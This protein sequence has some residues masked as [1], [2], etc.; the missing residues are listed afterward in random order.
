VR[1]SGR[2]YEIN[3]TQAD[4]EWAATTDP[5]RG[6]KRQAGKMAALYAEA[7]RRR[8]IIESDLLALE[9]AERE[10]QLVEAV[11][12]ER[13]RRREAERV[14]NALLSLPDKLAP[15]IAAANDAFIVHQMLTAAF[16]KTLRR[17]SSE[18]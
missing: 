14:I 5:L 17:L 15:L 10:A 11:A 2:F 7:R 13:E 18:G 12:V 8:T 4:R 1:R 6:G 3:V 16:R 9:F